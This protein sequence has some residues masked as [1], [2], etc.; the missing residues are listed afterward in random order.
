MPAFLPDL[1]ALIGPLLV[2][3]ITYYTTD[4]L[5]H[6]VSW[7]DALPPHLKRGLALTIASVITLGANALSVE[8]PTDLALW[9]PDTMDALVS[10][11]LA[12][13]VKAGNT[14]KAA[15]V[16][17]HEALVSGETPQ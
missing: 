4:Y 8:L 3:V 12:L 16:E 6:A 17:A 14:A 11:S 10:G 2:G 5:Q 13:A 7:I 15:K 9:T 1:I